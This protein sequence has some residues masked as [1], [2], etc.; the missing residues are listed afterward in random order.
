MDNLAAPRS[1]ERERRE[2]ELIEQIRMAG[3]VYL[4]AAEEYARISKEYR[5]LLDHPDRTMAL[6]KAA[7]NERIAFERYSQAL[8][9]LNQSILEGRPP[10]WANRTES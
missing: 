4:V 7:T 6:R 10:V 5:N 9:A 1:D 8:D 3:E 2:Q